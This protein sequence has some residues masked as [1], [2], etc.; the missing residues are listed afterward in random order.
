MSL[1]SNLVDHLAQHFNQNPQDLHEL[2]RYLFNAKQKIYTDYVND[3]KGY[4]TKFVLPNIESFASEMESKTAISQKDIQNAFLTDW[5]LSLT[6]EYNMYGNTYY[7]YLL[8]LMA[9]ATRINN[10]DLFQLCLQL[11]LFKIWNGRLSKSIKFC[12]PDTMNY[13]VTHMTTNKHLVRQYTDPYSLISSYFV[14]T[15][16]EKYFSQVKNDTSKL[17]LVFGQC[18][19]RV[20]QI[21]YQNFS[22]DLRTGAVSAKGGL[23][24]LYYQAKESNLKMSTISAKPTEDEEE[25]G[26]F[27]SGLSTSYNEDVIHSTLNHILMY[28]HQHY[29][30]ELIDRIK[31][32]TLLSEPGID[33]LI[34]II[35]N[36]KNEQYIKDLLTLFATM[37]PLTTSNKTTIC[38]R[39]FYNIVKSSII[40]TKNH[41]RI[42]NY[43]S[44]LDQ[45]LTNELPGYTNY[46]DVRKAHFRSAVTYLLAY[47]IQ[48]QLCSAGEGNA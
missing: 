8:L 23:A 27:A 18:F 26:I 12:D 13:V 24:P 47:N 33:K 15:L 36:P 4:C 46:S 32:E 40:S 34:K 39:N 48:K 3:F 29:A 9:Y 31:S 37:I 14:P 2:E 22:R 5:G 19:S 20:F 44:V 1:V 28:P 45:L 11:I 10:K 21:F 30:D 7:H 42:N 41:Q 43:R 6:R 16:T 35:H 38:S 25:Q 17:K